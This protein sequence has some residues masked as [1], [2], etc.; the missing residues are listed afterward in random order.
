MDFHQRRRSGW[1]TPADLSPPRNSVAWPPA[2]AARSRIGA[3]RRVAAQPALRAAPF[4]QLRRRADPSGAVT[5]GS[6]SRH[7]ASSPAKKS[8]RC[9]RRLAPEAG[10][11][12]LRHDVAAETALAPPRRRPRAPDSRTVSTPSCQQV[13]DSGSGL[14]AQA[15]TSSSA[16]ACRQLEAQRALRP[17]AAAAP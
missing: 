10:R 9:S 7:R 17:P 13:A 12:A 4:D 14:P 8:A 3:A 5:D 2:A 11:V 1:K 15:L 16:L 6:D